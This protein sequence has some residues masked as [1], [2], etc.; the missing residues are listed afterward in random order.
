[1][2]AIIQRVT[3]AS[4]EVNGNTISKIGKGIVVFL[5][6]STEDSEKDADYIC[7]KV[8]NCRIFYDDQVMQYFFSKLFII[9][10]KLFF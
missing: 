10:L 5:G 7:R 6:L 9:F 4:V 3:Q 1:M 8:L 2:R